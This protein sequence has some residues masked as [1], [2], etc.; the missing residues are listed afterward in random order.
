ML[1]V[2]VFCTILLLG[3]R[4]VGVRHRLIRANPEEMENIRPRRL[5]GGIRSQAS[6][7]GKKWAK[8]AVEEKYDELDECD[9][10]VKRMLSFSSQVVSGILY[11][12][13]YVI[14]SSSN[15][16]KCPK[17]LCFSEIF[18]QSWLHNKSV[19]KHKCRPKKD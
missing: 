6:A 17:K 1:R 4:A 19:S 5:M 9:Y 14:T 15:K 12:V 8:F 10:T 3:A 11:R 7:T 16:K 13:R 18:V 2:V